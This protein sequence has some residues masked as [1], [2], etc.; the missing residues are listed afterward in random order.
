MGAAWTPVAFQAAI[1]V[2][3]VCVGK[4]SKGMEHG[5]WSLIA[6]PLRNPLPHALCASFTRRQSSES[7]K[8]AHYRERLFSKNSAG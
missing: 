7:G 8:L 2:S 4:E 5:A 6:R 1:E 3:G